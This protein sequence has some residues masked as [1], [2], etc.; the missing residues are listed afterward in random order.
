M[1]QENKKYILEFVTLFLF[2]NYK[3]SY[4]RDQYITYFINHHYIIIFIF[5]MQL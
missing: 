2:R 5:I 4:L 3:N 1:P